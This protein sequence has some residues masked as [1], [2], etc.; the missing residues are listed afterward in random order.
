M[1]HFPSPA[2]GFSPGGDDFGVIR[3]LDGHN[4]GGIGLD[5]T[6]VH[7]GVDVIGDTGE[8]VEVETS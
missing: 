5:G 4:P 7:R 8:P 6:N 3:I 1:A 2:P